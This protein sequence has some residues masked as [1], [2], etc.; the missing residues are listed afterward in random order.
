MSIKHFRPRTSGQRRDYAISGPVGYGKPPRAHRF[1][2]GQSGNPKGRPKCS[3]NESTL[4]RDLLHRKIEVREGS[5]IRKVSVLEA[6]H[7]KIAEDSLKGNT[8][9]AAFLLNRYGAL[10]SGETPQSAMTED[11]EQILQE[12]IRRTQKSTGNPDQ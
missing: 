10:V 12:F 1:M 4:L 7:L 8:K 11:D 3:K 5:R 2:P 9:S 6:I